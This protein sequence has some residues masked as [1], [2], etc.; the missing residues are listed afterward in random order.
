MPILSE[1]NSILQESDTPDDIQRDQLND[2]SG[3]YD[4]SNI[5]GGKSRIHKK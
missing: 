1:L 2:H 5:A 3:N 4:H